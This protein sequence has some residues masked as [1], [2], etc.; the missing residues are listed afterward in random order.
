MEE[1][2]SFEEIYVSSFEKHFLSLSNVSPQCDQ[3]IVIRELGQSAL[4]VP[5]NRRSSLSAVLDS[6]KRRWS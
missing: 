1:L 3:D 2:Q 6:F 5:S 4:A